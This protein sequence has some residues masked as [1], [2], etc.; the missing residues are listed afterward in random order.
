M[1]EKRERM[2]RLGQEGTL[3]QRQ[4]KLCDWG[5]QDLDR[6]LKG[7]EQDERVKGQ[8]LRGRKRK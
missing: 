5:R 7:W 1:K 2:R 6:R 8:E 4:T 3:R